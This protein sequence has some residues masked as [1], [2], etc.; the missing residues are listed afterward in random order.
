MY[1]EQYNDVRSNTFKGVCSMSDDIIDTARNSVGAGSVMLLT[2]LVFNMEKARVD[3][4]RLCGVLSSKLAIA[5]S[6]AKWP[7]HI[8][9]TTRYE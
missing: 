3:K 5:M 6:S 7:L 4:D 2:M 8:T 9:Q 1:N